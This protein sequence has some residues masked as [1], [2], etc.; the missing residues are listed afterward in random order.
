M[1]DLTLDGELLHIR[2]ELALIVELSGNGK[3]TL[4]AGHPFYKVTFVGLTRGKS[5]KTLAV[6]LAFVEVSIVLVAA[7]HGFDGVSV[8]QTVEPGANKCFT[9]GHR[10]GTLTV[11]FAFK[12]LAL[13]DIVG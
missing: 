2:R 1:D 9:V 12:E 4:S 7:G 11:T 6:S 13:I 10:E 3:L 8:G 5:Q